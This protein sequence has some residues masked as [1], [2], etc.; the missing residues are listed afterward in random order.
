MFPRSSPGEVPSQIPIV[1][2]VSTAAALQPRPVS[3]RLAVPPE[4]SQIN[5][6][7]ILPPSVTMQRM[8]AK[9]VMNRQSSQVSDRRSMAE[10]AVIAADNEYADRK[11]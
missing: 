11:K 5:Q 7:R 6:M 4:R 10:S 8:N 9:L 1:V 3:D 2:R